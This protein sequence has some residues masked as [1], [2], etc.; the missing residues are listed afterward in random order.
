M[1]LIQVGTSAP[2]KLSG[3]AAEA[4]RRR[5]GSDDRLRDWLQSVLMKEAQAQAN[6][7]A[8]AAAKL[9]PREDDQPT[10]PP[11]SSEPPA[12]VQTVL[13]K[14]QERREPD[15]WSATVHLPSGAAWIVGISGGEPYWAQK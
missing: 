11:V 15:G 7:E 3:R 6:I 8:I 1:I 2:L 13:R 9:Q 10:L 12:E 14:A 5:I 4:L